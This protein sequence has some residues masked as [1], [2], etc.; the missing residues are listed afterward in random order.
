MDI[1][2]VNKLIIYLAYIFSLAWTF[3]QEIFW[4]CQIKWKKGSWADL[5]GF[6]VYNISFWQSPHLLFKLVQKAL[7]WTY[8]CSSTSL[9]VYTIIINEC[10][11][12]RRKIH[13]SMFS[14]FM[15]GPNEILEWN[16]LCD[17]GM[18][19]RWLLQVQDIWF[20]HKLDYIRTVF[21]P[22]ICLQLPC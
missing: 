4:T 5:L 6:N 15:T 22:L 18:I 16:L 9:C 13:Q 3:D 14:G 11:E 17:T 7:R 8:L 10:E 12:T 1:G 19:N 21:N 20:F 2:K